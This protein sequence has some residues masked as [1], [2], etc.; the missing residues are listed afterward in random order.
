MAEFTRADAIKIQSKQIKY[1]SNLIKDP[2]KKS[3]FLKKIRELKKGNAIART[4]YEIPRG[5]QIEEL[6]YKINLEYSDEQYYKY[7]ESLD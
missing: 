1:Y 6:Y 5:T 2:K 4:P 7:L 3:M